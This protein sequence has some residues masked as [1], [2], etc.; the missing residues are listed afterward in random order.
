MDS[1]D[2]GVV[3]FTPDDTHSMRG[4]KSAVPR[5]NAIFE[6]GMLIGRLRR[7]NVFLVCP[8]GNE[9]SLPSD[10]AGIV[11]VTYKLRSDSNHTAA[12][13][14]AC[15]QILQALT[16]TEPGPQQNVTLWNNVQERHRDGSDLRTQL[17]EAQHHVFVSGICLKILG[18]VLCQATEFCT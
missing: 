4:V 5:D 3:I 18:Y 11:K 7:Q 12:V 6:L 16:S 2:A 15:R 14:T 13:S 1:H 10:L 8:E 9:I 17:H